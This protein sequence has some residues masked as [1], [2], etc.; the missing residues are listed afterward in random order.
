MEGMLAFC[1]SQVQ[2]KKKKTNTKEYVIVL[3]WS[4][5]KQCSQAQQV[6][7]LS[8]RQAWAI[9]IIFEPLDQ[10]SSAFPYCTANMIFMKHQAK[11]WNNFWMQCTV[12]WMA[13]VQFPYTIVTDCTSAEA[14]C[15]HTYHKISYLFLFLK[16]PM[17][18]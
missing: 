18:L 16:L 14:E 1:R 12:L 13:D 17:F 11:T 3:K 4:L 6:L 15:T 9:S 5:S 8:F 2:L 7:H 10:F